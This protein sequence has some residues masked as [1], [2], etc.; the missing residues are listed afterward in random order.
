MIRFR[1]SGLASVQFPELCSSQG[2]LRLVGVPAS[3]V[4]SEMQE[5]L[6]RSGQIGS[7]GDKSGSKST[8]KDDSGH[9]DPFDKP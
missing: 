4:A 2:S 8:S 7:V 3:K 6:Q 1:A 9:L 5:S